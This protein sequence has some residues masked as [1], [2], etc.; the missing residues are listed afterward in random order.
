VFLPLDYLERERAAIERHLGEAHK[1]GD[2]PYRVAVTTDRDAAKAAEANRGL[3]LSDAIPASLRDRIRA[4]RKRLE[5][6]QEEAAELFRVSREMWAAWET[7][8]KAIPPKRAEA[9]ERWAAS[10]RSGDA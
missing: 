3:A 1:R 9:L 7:G 10:G 4:A 8:R 2:V 6:S 5:L